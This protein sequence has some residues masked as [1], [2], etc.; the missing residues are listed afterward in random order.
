MSSFATGLGPLFVGVAISITL[1]GVTLAQFFF[2]LFNFH[3]DGLLFKSFVIFLCCLDTAGSMFNVQFLWYYLIKSRANPLLA[4][5][6]LPAFSA[7]HAIESTA[8]FIVQCFYIHNIWT[9]SAV[10]HSAARMRPYRT[11]LT[12][13]ALILALISFAGGLAVTVE[14]S[15]TTNAHKLLEKLTIPGIIQP[16]AAALT[17]VYIAVSLCWILDRARTGLRGTEGLVA[18]LSIYAI[19]RGILTS[20][21]QILQLATYLSD[22][23]HGTFLV[24]IFSIPGSTLYINSLLAVLNARHHLRARLYPDSDLELSVALSMPF[25]LSGTV[26]SPSLAVGPGTAVIEAVPRRGRGRGR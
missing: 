16:L 11:P 24:D 6:V 22:I 13:T 23:A 9:L 2:Y 8:I 18:K 15:S 12:V 1:Y 3:Q 19:N 14:T 25:S 17:D 5:F 21:I 10:I 7:Q 20:T 26:P 4:T